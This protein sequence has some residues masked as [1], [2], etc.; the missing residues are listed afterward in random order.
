MVTRSALPLASTDSA[1]SMLL[2]RPTAM[3]GT[4]TTERM[5]AAL[6]T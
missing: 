5:A 4:L 1:T 6:S 2:M 3:T